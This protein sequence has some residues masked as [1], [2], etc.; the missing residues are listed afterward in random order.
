MKKRFDLT[1]KQNKI[2][3]LGAILFLVLIGVLSMFFMPFFNQMSE[4]AFQRKFQEWA[5]QQ[6]WKGYLVMLSIQIIQIIIAF[7]P[8]EPVE[9]L[10]GFLYGPW[11][12]LLLCLTGCIFAST[13]VFAFIRKFGSRIIEKIFSKEKMQDFNFLQNSKKI[14]VVTFV[15]FLIPG[16]PKDL[17][18]YVAG[19]SP[20]RFV[21]F[22]ILSTLARIP[23]IISSTFM[24]A[25]MGEGDWGTSIVIFIATAAIGLLGIFFKDRILRYCHNLERRTRKK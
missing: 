8:G 21:D 5:V 22:L 9:L 7:I 24:G 20:I 10:A 14:E 11:G 3:L 23:S 13:M 17:L 4:P 19:A 6:T 1:R 25:T 2:L 16:T 15:L 18:T 12:G